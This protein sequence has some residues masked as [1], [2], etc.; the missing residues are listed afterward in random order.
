M[1]ALD[2][3]TVYFT[4]TLVNTVGLLMMFI[5][6]KQSKKRFEGTHFFIL[7][8]LFQIICLALIFLRGHIP[9]FFSMVVSITFSIS[10][11]FMSIIGLSKFTGKKINYPINIL[12]IAEVFAVQVWFA[13]I[14]DNLEVRNFNFSLIFMI[15]SIQAAW[16]LL[17]KVPAALKNLTVWVGIIFIFFA[18]VD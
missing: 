4:F 8:F 11:T 1:N 2:I 5:L 9:D 3:R 13:I 18:L 10:G 14:N 7:D 16:I 12:L 15:L 6:W 17:V